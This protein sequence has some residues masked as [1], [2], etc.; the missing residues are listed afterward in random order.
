MEQEMS[1]TV[2]TP[3]MSMRSSLVPIDMFSTLVTRNA[4]PSYFYFSKWGFV[5]VCVVL[6]YFSLEGSGYNI[7]LV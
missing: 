7:L 3:V 6:L 2:C 1:A 5:C 4:G